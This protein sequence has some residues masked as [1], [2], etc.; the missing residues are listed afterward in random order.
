M[1]PIAASVLAGL[2]AAL[3]GAAPATGGEGQAAVLLSITPA[4]DTS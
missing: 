3:V 1:K 2:A 4:A